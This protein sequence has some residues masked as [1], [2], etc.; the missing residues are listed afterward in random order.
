M[1]GAAI[2]RSTLVCSKIPIYV[3]EEDL[4]NHF[5]L[6]GDVAELIYTQRERKLTILSIL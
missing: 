5:A 6:F 3:K 2:E 4:I 1:V